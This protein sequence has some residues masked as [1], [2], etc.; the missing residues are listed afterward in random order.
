MNMTYDELIKR[1]R[2]YQANPLCKWQAHGE[3]FGLYMERC[4]WGDKPKALWRA[5]TGDDG[6]LYA[7]NLL[8]LK[9]GVKSW[10]QNKEVAE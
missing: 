2:Y 8:G 5:R 6:Y 10:V 4:Y 9:A 7:D 1:V 3:Y